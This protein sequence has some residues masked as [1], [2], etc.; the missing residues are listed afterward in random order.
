MRASLCLSA[1][2]LSGG[3]ASFAA[4]VI[5]APAVLLETARLVPSDGA[6]NGGFGR[7]LAIKGGVAVVTANAQS[8]V[9]GSGPD[10][11]GAAY[12]FERDSSGVWRQTAKLTSG[13]E[14]DLYGT[15]V[16]VDNNI[17]VVGAL[18]SHVTYVYEKRAGSWQL[19]AT[20][21]TSTGGG[22][23]FS[24]ATANTHIAISQDPPHGMVIYRRETSGWVR[25]ASYQ[26]GVGLDDDE[27]FGPQVDISQN[28]AIHGSF[29]A[30]SPPIPATAF[31]YTPADGGNVNW[32]TPAVTALTRPG[33][34]AG[35]GG[36]SSR[37]SISG[38][39]ALINDWLFSP[40]ASGQWVNIGQVPLAIALDDDDTRVLGH[41]PPFRNIS[42]YR[43]NSAGPWPLSAELVASESREFTAADVNAGRAL[44]AS[45]PNKIAYVFETPENLDRPALS[46]DDFQD[47]DANG[48]AT[49]PGSL[50]AVASSGTF[51]F[52]R[53]SSVAGNSVALWQAAIGNDQSI[54]ADITPRA[55]DGAD[56]WFGLVARY[57]DINNYYY[58]TARSGGSLQLKRML[59]GRYTT[60]GTA[61]MPVAIGTPN[62]IRL[63]AVGNHVRVFVNQNAVIRVRISAL[64]G[65]RPGLITFKARA[66]FD[67]VVVNANPAYLAFA[68]NFEGRRN[69]WQIQVE[70]DWPVVFA[71]GSH[72]RRN[73]DVTGSARL[74]IAGAGQASFGTPGDQVVQADLRPTL[75]SGT[76]R[77]VG[78]MARY[79]DD[80][81]YHY[82]T[83]RNSGFLDIRKLVNG[84]VVRLA[85]VPFTVQPNVNY[86]V[87][88]ETV[89][90]SL[91][92]FVNGR[93]RAEATDASLTPGISSAGV[94]TFKAAVDVDN[95]SLLQP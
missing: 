19:M 75:F 84:S 17:I 38:N 39:T 72:V 32:Q 44:V 11:L 62:R 69:N 1:L 12:V 76:D 13:D 33:G 8:R 87:R 31:I 22:N 26:N 86:R 92:A 29:G 21:G 7:A 63:E 77:W 20:L 93:L 25:I 42:L 5:A 55:F 10:L 2:V 83:L 46:Q 37:V 74:V 3:L 70:G 43:R 34:D 47:G 23:G 73:T 81:N 56:R 28:F 50:F 59:A 67:N 16:G 14:G 6:P 88:L 79:H 58:V 40:N 71:N 15:D 57:T 78:V 49:T 41:A 66:D 82:V 24:V 89:G 64:S 85:R 4:P 52:Y 51:R 90:T 68:D 36:F 91:R 9:F 80:A 45:Y 35:P 61:S 53:Q 95:F 65:G 94:V 60:L 48:W 30:E 54:Q 18:F 27:Y